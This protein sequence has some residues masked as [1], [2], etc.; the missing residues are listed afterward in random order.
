MVLGVLFVVMIIVSAGMTVYTMQVING[1][2]HD[3]ALLRQ[4]VSNLNDQ[5]TSLTSQVSQ[6]Q[7]PNAELTSEVDRLN[8]IVSGLN[9]MITNVND[10]VTSLTQAE[11][12]TALGSNYVTTGTP[13]LY[14]AGSV[15]NTGR[16]TAYNVGLHVIAYTANRQK[17]IDMTVPFFFENTYS[18]STGSTTLMTVSSMQNMSVSI[19]IKASSALTNWTIT[20]VWTNSP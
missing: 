8:G 9:G 6:F 10:K 7:S 19:N 2:N 20:P 17:I 4:Q 16:G 18:T 12:V 5:V 11:L 14:I 13:R 15:I 1:N 3:V